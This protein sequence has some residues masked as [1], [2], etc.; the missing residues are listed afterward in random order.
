M[1]LY[2]QKWF[3]VLLKIETPL[4]GKVEV[5]GNHCSFILLPISDLKYS[6]PITKDTCGY[7]ILNPDLDQGKHD[8]YEYCFNT[9]TMYLAPQ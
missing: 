6:I 9:V 2:P 3:S 8:Y 5:N 1:Y 4:C 7:Q